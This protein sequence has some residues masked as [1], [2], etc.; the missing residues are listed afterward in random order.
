MAT[1]QSF[2][3]LNAEATE[4]Q[5][6]MGIS[7]YA[8]LDDIDFDLDDN[9]EPS[10]ADNSMIDENTETVPAGTQDD[11]MQDGTNEI[12]ILDLEDDLIMDPEEDVFNDDDNEK[13][14]VSMPEH[15]VPASLN[16]ED[17]TA[18]V[19]HVEV[20]DSK[21][22]D[23]QDA[24]TEE[25]LLLEEEDTNDQ[26]TNHNIDLT[27]DI[28]SHEADQITGDI[29]DSIQVA[30]GEIEQSTTDTVDLAPDAASNT[31]IEPGHP[32][33][34]L[35]ND[36]KPQSKADEANTIES[37]HEAISYNS[38][39]N[40]HDDLTQQ[41]P[42]ILPDEPHAEQDR[43]PFQE[44]A[45]TTLHPITL[46][47]QG[48]D[49][50]LFP[51][52]EEDDSTTYFLEDPTLAFT[53]FDKLL[54]ACRDL[55]GDS[56]GHDDEIVI[57][58][59]SL[60]L[61]ICEDSKYAAQLTLAQ[62]IDTYMLLSQNEQLSPIEPLYCELSHRVCLATQMA[63][64]AQSAREGKTYSAILAE[65]A[66]SPEPEEPVEE[67]YADTTTYHDAADDLDANGTL[68]EATAAI[69]ATEVDPN[70]PIGEGEAQAPEPPEVHVRETSFHADEPHD[71][72]QKSDVLDDDLVETLEVP[73]GDQDV[74]GSYKPGDDDAA[75]RS[76]HTLEGDHA[77]TT[78]L[79]ETAPKELDDD[80]VNDNG[81]YIAL[82][83]DFIDDN[84]AESKPE[85][86]A[87]VTSANHVHHE[88]VLEVFVD[89]GT[90]QDEFD[91]D[92]FL[93]EED[94]SI[95]ENAPSTAV[96]A[97]PSKTLNGKRK[98]MDDDDDNDSLEFDLST[99]DPKRT[100]A[101]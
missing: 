2:A 75:S 17:V 63:Y 33:P 28:D 59:P 93:D 72:D 88:E 82:E 10:I 3:N 99:P 9:R 97:T 84:D 56:L 70:R 30:G 60:G 34:I 4:D 24:P 50:S 40:E 45:A 64:L 86:I 46:R 83:D 39:Q 74:E 52:L 48:Q 26:D 25:E 100:K 57:D 92:E 91:L 51:P 16:V 81:D 27:V 15:P 32:E 29:I 73:S 66:D 23:G 58:V 101:S 43:S 49:M 35:Y 11:T 95:A 8:Q 69:E 6:E 55:L 76:S 18:V 44:S 5:M 77:D 96:L 79:E 1:I 38:Q 85:T 89:K 21:N 87:Y 20:E 65:H 19:E 41:P 68:D 62:V 71:T 12:D 13:S 98:A 42:E 78:R 22:E 67:E 90:A 36:S 31:N 14:H 54:T 80:L 47:Y 37:A 94:D 61:H 53:T 7:P